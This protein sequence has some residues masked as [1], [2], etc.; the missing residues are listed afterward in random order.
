MGSG[1]GGTNAWGQEH[2]ALVDATTSATV[3]RLGT[4]DLSRSSP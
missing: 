4:F 1:T 2:A 3:E